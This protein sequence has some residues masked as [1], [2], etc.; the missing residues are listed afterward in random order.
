MFCRMCGK[1]IPDG[2]TICE[3]CDTTKDVSIKKETSSQE[4]I[5]FYIALIIVILTVI[6]FGKFVVSLYAVASLVSLVFSI[7]VLIKYKNSKA[8]LAA[9]LLN[10]WGLA[11]NIVWIMYV[12]SI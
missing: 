5:A 12:N 3:T 2:Q 8:G 4:K 9:L 10:I 6:P 7:Y 1:E 11:V